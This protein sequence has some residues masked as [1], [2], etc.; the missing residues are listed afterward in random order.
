MIHRPLVKK[1]VLIVFLST[2]LIMPFVSLNCNPVGL[3][4]SALMCRMQTLTQTKV[5]FEHIKQLMLAIINNSNFLQLVL[6]IIIFYLVTFA[7]K[8]RRLGNKINLNYFVAVIKPKNS[9]N[10]ALARGII[11]GKYFD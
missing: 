11:H 5:Q 6:S 9:L 4:D 10:F 1:I 8:D 3:S 7:I 2:L